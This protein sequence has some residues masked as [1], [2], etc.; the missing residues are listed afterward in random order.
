MTKSS[1]I[2]AIEK[3]TKIKWAEWLVFLEKIK[4]KELDHT[5][6]ADK[7][8][9]KLK[10]S[11][12]NAG[13]WSQAVAVAYEQ[14][15]GRRK[16]G[17][18]SDGTY[19][20]AINKTLNGDMDQ[21]INA[22]LKLIKDWSDFGGVKFIGKPSMTATDKRRHWGVNLTDGSRVNADVYPK[23]ADKVNLSVTHMKLASEKAKETWRAYW[24]SALE[25]L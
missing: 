5:Q 22:W 1:N 20:V 13:W 7:I 14:H 11:L 6:M 21:A 8:Y 10:P 17:Q 25:N 4:A 23:S 2:P 24:K 16:P 12:N 18:R 3:A 15:I 19:E 9:Q